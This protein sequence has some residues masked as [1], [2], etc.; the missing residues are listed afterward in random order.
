M[1]LS[2]KKVLLIVIHIQTHILNLI[3]LLF[4]LPPPSTPLQPFS[5]LII[6]YSVI[7]ENKKMKKKK[8]MILIF[9]ILYSVIIYLSSCVLLAIIERR[10]VI[11][12]GL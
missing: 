5:V 4:S 1:T 10:R 11:L 12:L 9:Y 8:Q 6:S 3:L 2:L 7:E